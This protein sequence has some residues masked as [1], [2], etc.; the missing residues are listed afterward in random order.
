[1]GSTAKCKVSQQQTSQ[2]QKAAFSSAQGCLRQVDQGDSFGLQGLE[3]VAVFLF[4]CV[5]LL[6]PLLPLLMARAGAGDEVLEDS[7]AGQSVQIGNERVPASS[8]HVLNRSPGSTTYGRQGGLV[9]IDATWV[10]RAP[11]GTWLVAIAQGQRMESDMAV[12]PWNRTPLQ[13]TWIWR[14]SSEAQIR[15]MLR[16]DRTACQRLFGAS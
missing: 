3:M 12:L 4:A 14:H 6:A 10:C 11:D 13:I 2:E 9:Q 15:G 8:L 7:F 5:L 16:H 1:M